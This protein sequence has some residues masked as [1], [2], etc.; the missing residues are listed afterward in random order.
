MALETNLNEKR[1]KR[2]EILP[3]ASSLEARASWPA[4]FFSRGWAKL[5]PLPPLLLAFAWASP[6]A[7][8]ATRASLPCDTDSR[9]PLSNAPSSSCHGRARDRR[10]LQPNQSGILGLPNRTRHIGSINV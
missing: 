9:D 8:A 1:K 4:P 5:S 2:E 7:T 10:R 6:G 3:A